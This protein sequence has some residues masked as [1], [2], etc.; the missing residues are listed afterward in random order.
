[1]LDNSR[2]PVCQHAL[3][4]P[5]PHHVG[6]TGRMMCGCVTLKD[7]QFLVS[8]NRLSFFEGS[9]HFAIM[10]GLFERSLHLSRA[11]E[12]RLFIL[13]LLLCSIGFFCFISTLVPRSLFCLIS[14][15]REC[16]WRSQSSRCV[17]RLQFLQ[18]LLYTGPGCHP[19]WL[20]LPA[21]FVPLIIDYF[22]H[23]I[24]GWRQRLVALSLVEFPCQASCMNT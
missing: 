18:S 23:L 1:M 24:R 4:F 7:T 16:S 3:S 20:L 15:P 19:G 2:Y 10:L 21:L 6:A 11:L 22:I 5:N 14:M 12:Q 13:P 17:P 8:Y 9:L